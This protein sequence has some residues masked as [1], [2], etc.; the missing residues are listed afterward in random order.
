VRGLEAL[1]CPRGVAVVGSASPGKIGYHLIEQL[2]AGGFEAVYAVNP[3]GQ[4]AWDVP[5]Y[6]SIADVGAPVDLAVVASPPSTVAGVLEACGEAGVGAAVIITSGFAE[7]GNVAGEEEVVATARR[8][9]IRFVGPNCAGLLNTAHDLHPTL[10]VRPPA[11]RVALISQSGALGGAVLGWAEEQGLGFSK[12]VSYGNGAD[13]KAVDFLEYLAEDP[14]TDVVALYV[15]SVADGRAFMRAA[16]TLA[17]RKPLVVIKSGRTETGRRATLSHTGALAGSDAVYDA[18]LRRAGALRVAGVEALFDLCRGFVSL[19]PA[20]GRRVAVV[21]NSGGPG[22]LAADHAEALGLS[23]AETSPALREELAEFLPSHCALRNP[24]DLTVEGTEAGYRRTLEAVLAEYDAALALDVS[25]PYLDA[26]AHARG[27]CAAAA[28]SGKPVVANFAAGRA[29]AEAL[30]ALEACGVPNYPT[31]ERAMGVLAGMAKY[32]EMRAALRP[33]PE[34]PPPARDSEVF[35]R[36][37]ALLEPEAMAWLRENGLPVPEFRFAGAEEGAVEACREMGYPAVMKVVSPGILHK[38][39]VGGVK[40]GL[41]DDEEARE[42]FRALR[43]AAVSAGAEFR[44]VVVYP[45]LRDGV[46]VLVGLSR[47]PQFGPVV[48]LGLGGIYTEVLKDVALRVAPV[49]E[50]EA[51]VMIR[52]LRSYPLLAG[53]RGGR[54]RDVEALARLVA[55]FSVLPFRYPRVAEADLNPVFVFEEGALVGDVRVVC[56]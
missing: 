22:V 41:G 32:G 13:L 51:L 25:T 48:A 40:V 8:H 55:D 9:G 46:E 31:G 37:G 43:K 12:F 44:G 36:A 23:V 49:D 34:P 24:I 18:A 50:G 3:R 27:V 1:F 7:V 38:S 28:S 45:L 26:A 52:E 16:R 11:G 2:V 15:E 19:P 54:R 35:C 14:D 20:A 56:R 33:L 21:T 42:A 29:V 47:D 39:D 5:G 6:A 30:P 17:A 10:E 53:V 4:G